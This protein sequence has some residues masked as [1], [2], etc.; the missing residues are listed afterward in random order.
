[1]GAG[2]TAPGGLSGPVLAAALTLV[3]ALSSLARCADDLRRWSDRRHGQ[4]VVG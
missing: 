4:K 2:R 3:L 1:M